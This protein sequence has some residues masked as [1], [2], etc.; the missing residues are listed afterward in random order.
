MYGDYK[1]GDV[2]YVDCVGVVEITHPETGGRWVGKFI[3]TEYGQPRY[4][5]F[6]EKKIKFRC[7]E[8]I[9]PER[10]Y[11]TPHYFVD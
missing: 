3:R 7:I 10:K 2:V 11:Q 1:V 5:V 6:S 9:Q 8:V 4:Y